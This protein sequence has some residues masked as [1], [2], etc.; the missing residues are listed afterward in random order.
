MYADSVE[1][2]GIGVIT[3]ILGTL[4]VWICKKVYGT[5]EE[6]KAKKLAKAYSE[7]YSKRLERKRRRKN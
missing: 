7:F 1:K 6:R 5:E 3:F 2:V 4:I